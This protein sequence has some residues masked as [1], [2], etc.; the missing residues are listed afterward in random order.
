MFVTDEPAGKKAI[1]LVST[2]YQEFPCVLEKLDT[3]G[4]VL[5]EYWSDGYIYSLS[6]REVDHHRVLDVGAVNNGPG[7]PASRGPRPGPRGR[8]GSSDVREVRLSGLSARPPDGV[9]GADPHGRGCR[10]GWPG[11][12]ARDHRRPRRAAAA[13]GAPARPAWRG[14]RPAVRV[15]TSSICS[16]GTCRVIDAEFGDTY[17]AAHRMLEG[18]GLLNKPFVND[19][20][21]LFPV[22]RWDGA[23]F[24]E[25]TGPEVSR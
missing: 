21:L 15:P 2:H 9:P 7:A 22:R 23:K 19:R 6:Q 16:T 8:I 5:G 25:M 4:N 24:V 12:G 3:A 20:S 18:S 14:S 17:A 13:R 10:D 1:W 11:L